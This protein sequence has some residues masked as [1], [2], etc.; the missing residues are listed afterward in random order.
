MKLTNNRLATVLGYLQLS[1]KTPLDKSVWVKAIG[2]HR[3][4]IKYV[5][6]HCVQ[7]VLST[8]QAYYKL[9]P[10]MHNHP[11][12]NLTTGKTEACPTCGAVG[13][14]TKQGIRFRIARTRRY[15]RYLCKEC[16]SWSHGKATNVN[17]IH[18]S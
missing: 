1:D 12:V 8:E 7:D 17:D 14:L 10:L 13:S 6:D 18:I 2:G 4:S 3:E 9:R 15:Q 11:N 5:T 16:G